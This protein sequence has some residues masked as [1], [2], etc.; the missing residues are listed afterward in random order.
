MPIGFGDPEASSGCHLV[1]AYAMRCKTR[2]DKNENF[3]RK[4]T[5]TSDLNDRLQSLI[6]G[7]E[8]HLH[9]GDGKKYPFEATKTRRAAMAEENLAAE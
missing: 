1:K 8:I 2:A 4:I 7:D 6:S 5:K 9:P 3:E